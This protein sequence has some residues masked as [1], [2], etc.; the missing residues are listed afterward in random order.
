LLENT[1]SLIYESLHYILH[2]AV[3]NLREARMFLLAQHLWDILKV[4]NWLQDHM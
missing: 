1:Y 4:W 2:T 3:C